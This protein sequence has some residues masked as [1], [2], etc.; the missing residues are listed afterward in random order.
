MAGISN[1]LIYEVL[2]NVQSRVGNLEDGM[3]D[4]KNE[5]VGIRE[6]QIATQKEVA[7]IYGRLGSIE[8]RLERVETRLNMAGEPA[9]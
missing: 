1:E 5:L 9:E 4:V 8:G 6:H 7:N 3:K 2:K